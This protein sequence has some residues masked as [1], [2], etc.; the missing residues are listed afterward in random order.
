MKEIATYPSLENKV[1]VITGGASGIGENI[2]EHF[3]MQKSVVAF[4]DIDENLGKELVIKLEKKYKSKLYFIKCDLKNIKELQKSIQFIREKLGPIYSLINNAAND[5]RHTLDSVTP[6]YWD[7]R[8]SINLKHYFF[9]S[10]AVYKD[11]KEIGSG[12]I[13]N[14][15]SFS[16]MLAQGGM[17]GYTTAKSAIMGLTRTLARDLGEFNIRVNCVVPGWII[18]E[19][20]KKMWLTPEIESKQLERQC[21]KRMLIPDDI[22]KAVLFF[23]SDQ[24]SGCTAQNYIVDG[25]IVN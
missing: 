17:P 14:I 7:D 16:W 23:A 2:V 13:V 10:Q 21:I 1:I 8:M 18:T 6:E 9:A 5:E 11:M 15:G 20:Q 12:T 4:L 24:S 19:R 3:I 22:S 25:G